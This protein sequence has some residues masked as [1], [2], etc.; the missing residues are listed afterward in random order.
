[1]YVGNSLGT[2]WELIGNSQGT[3][4]ELIGNSLSLCMDLQ[5]RDKYVLLPMDFL[6]IL[7]QNRRF[8]P[9]ILLIESP[10]LC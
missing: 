10:I 2:H 3:H 8:A 1:M 4:R 7:S 9:R 6:H 5:M